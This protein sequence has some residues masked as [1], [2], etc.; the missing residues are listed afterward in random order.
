MEFRFPLSAFGSA[1]RNWIRAFRLPRR[2]L[3]GEGGFNPH[4]ET[5]PG[6]AL[7]K[8][9]VP[10]PYGPPGGGRSRDPKLTPC[11]L[12]LSMQYVFRQ[13]VPGCLS[14]SPCLFHRFHSV[15]HV[16]RVPIAGL[17]GL[18]RIP[19]QRLYVFHSQFQVGFLADPIEQHN[20]IMC[21][22]KLDPQAS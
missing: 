16:D 3:A 21:L 11:P 14:D 22:G 17:A 6:E 20:Q 12:G 1:L 5:C 13:H 10:K 7:A 4:S 19:I 2:S 15:L 8:P 9:E 18:C